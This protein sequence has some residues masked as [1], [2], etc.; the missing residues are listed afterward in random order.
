MIGRTHLAAGLC[1]SL[2]VAP[3]AGELSLTHVA[4]AGL[5]GVF[6]DFDASGQQA[7]VAHMGLRLTRRF[8]FKPFMPLCVLGSR[9]FAHRT[10][11]HTL[12]AALI[13][14]LLVGGIALLLSAPTPWLSALAFFFGYTSHLL[15]DAMTP[16]GV[17]LY[18]PL[19]RITQCRH[20]VP[21]GWRVP[22]G[23]PLDH[24]LGVLCLV[25]FGIGFYWWVSGGAVVL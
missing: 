20:V 4:L 6:P 8:T 5:G 12:V 10:Y 15:L 17:P 2:L 7:T 25:G 14:G 13:G 19:L 23:S 1:M 11:T 18:W 9:L 16:H 21:R 3:L 24:A 22:T